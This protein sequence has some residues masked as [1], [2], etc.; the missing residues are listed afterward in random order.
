MPY[1]H[2]Y[3]SSHLNS[4]HQ[5]LERLPRSS[6]RGKFLAIGA[7]LLLL[8]LTSMANGKP[9]VWAADDT[10]GGDTIPDRTLY[11]PLLQQASGPTPEPTPSPTPTPTPTP[12]PIP[13]YDSIPT[14]GSPPDHPPEQHGDLNLELRGYSETSGPLTLLEINGPTDN[15]APQLAGIFNDMRGPDFVSLFRVNDWNWA[16]GDHGCRGNPIENPPVTLLG[17]R[18][19]LGEPLYIPTRIPE[20]Y[21]DGYKVLVLYATH[22]RI[23]LAYTREDSAAIGYVVHLEA[24]AVDPSLVALYQR[25]DTEGRDRLPAL[26]N[27]ERLGDAV[28]DVVKVVIRDTGSFMEPRSRKDWW[29]A[30]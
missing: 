5:S 24:I 23:T 18:A 22:E 4:K 11:L 30:Y 29:M 8:M 25:L 28:S 27:G 3:P 20:I 7:F 21:G 6:R 13:V 1:P 12:T 26:R 19:T 2:P 16:C 14:L 15:N 9:A 17:L 10:I